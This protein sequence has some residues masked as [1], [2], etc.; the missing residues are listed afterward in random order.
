MKYILDMK[1]FCQKVPH[2]DEK[3]Y[4]ERF[5]RYRIEDA[6]G[7]L[8]ALVWF[9]QMVD[10]GNIYSVSVALKK[11]YLRDCFDIYITNGVE[12]REFYPVRFEMSLKGERLTTENYHQYIYALAEGYTIAQTI[13]EIFKDE[14]HLRKHKEG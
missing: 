13:M 2:S 8:V 6:Y 3:N 14:E 1:E 10:S 5:Y 9:S 11:E 4:N 12:N 7:T